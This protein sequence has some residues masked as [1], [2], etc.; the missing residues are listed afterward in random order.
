MF[1]YYLQFPQYL[2]CRLNLKYRQ[3]PQFPWFLKNL[4]FHHF[5]LYR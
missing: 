5:L 1:H 4:M 2:L 3:S